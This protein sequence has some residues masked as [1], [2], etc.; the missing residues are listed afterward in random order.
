MAILTPKASP[1]E[2]V[3][4]PHEHD[5]RLA[6][7]DRRVQ[8]AV[9]RQFQPRQRVQRQPVPGRAAWHQARAQPAVLRRR[10]R[11]LG[12][13]SGLLGPPS[14]G[15]AG[16]TSLG[17]LDS[18][19]LLPACLRA[20]QGLRPPLCGQLPLGRRAGGRELK[21]LQ[22]PMPGDGRP[23][24]AALWLP[25]RHRRDRRASCGGRR[26]RT[27]A[28][29]DGVMLRH[30]HSRP[31]TQRPVPLAGLAVFGARIRAR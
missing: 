8:R 22:R 15:W 20:D 28:A 5:G 14:P 2:R 6:A 30:W 10:R 23:I 11:R 21:R 19:Q 1:G 17:P 9:C 3:A 13:F 16:S 29:A 24:C 18:R 31:R 12:E 27:G 25:R 4:Q 7:R 26:V